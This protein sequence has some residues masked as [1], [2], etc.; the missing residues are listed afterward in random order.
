MKKKKWILF[1]I[2]IVMIV[3]MGARAY[4]TAKQI[5]AKDLENLDDP[6]TKLKI[7]EILVKDMG[8]EKEM[9]ASEIKKIKV[10]RGETMEQ[11]KEDV[12]IVGD[13]GP[14]LTLAAAY[15]AVNGGY[16]FLGTI[17]VFFDVQEVSNIYLENL[18]RDAVFLKE[19][20]EQNGDTLEKATYLRGYVWEN[21]GYKLIYSMPEQLCA[22]WSNGSEGSGEIQWQRVV[23]NSKTRLENGNYPLITSRRDQSYMISG[24]TATRN[25]PA[26]ETFN[27]VINRDTSESYYWSDSWGQFILGE[28]IDKT[29]GE[30]VA[31][32]EDW[33][34]LVYSMVPEFE[35]YKTKV[36]IMRK[37][38]TTDV[39]QKDS[40][41][42]VRENKKILEET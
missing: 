6:A 13:Y 37:D 35:A 5:T 14:N 7:S 17:G 24:D 29:T 34:N 23:Q 10:T 31:V 33:G 2:F 1:V 18:K 26:D 42:E 15:E 8:K 41:S 16:R 27:K 36:K 20:T 12:I 30:K 32:I 11:G 40:L 25:R 22:E 39:V 19:Y 9:D 28:K 21:D 4:A 38:G 3:G